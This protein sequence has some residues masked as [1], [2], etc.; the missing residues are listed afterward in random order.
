MPQYLA[1]L[2]DH[3]FLLNDVFQV[4]AL[5]QTERFQDATLDIYD[6][7]LEEAAKYAE[8]VLAPINRSGDEEGCHLENGAVKTPSGFP[9]A[10]G[11]FREGGWAGISAEIEHG[12][13]GLPHSL[14]ILVDEI[15]TAANP[16]FG[17]YRGLIDGAYRTILKYGSD[18]LKESYLHRLAT[19][20]LLPTM[21]L[22]EPHC[23]SDL[24]LLRTRAE[25]ENDG[26]Y[27]ITGTKIFIT[28]GEHDLTPNILHLVLARL[29]DAPAGSR[30]ISLFLVPKLYTGSDGAEIR[31]SLA[32]GGIEHKMGLKASATCV[33]N[34]DGAKGWLLGPPHGGLA[35]MF[36]MMNSARLGV[37]MQGIAAIEAVLQISSTYAAERKQGKAPGVPGFGPDAITH[38]PDVRRMIQTQKAFAEGGR[39]LAL[40]MALAIDHSHCA[41]DP[42]E[43]ERHDELAQLLTPIVK[44][45]LTDAGNEATNIGLQILGG[46]GY[47]REW[48]VEQWVRDIRIAAIY[49]GTNGIQG[50]D[51]V[52]RKLT[53]K[54]GRLPK[55][56]FESLRR[57]FDGVSVLMPVF[58]VARDA[59]TSLELITAR[60]QAADDAIRA[61]VA[62]EFLS[63]FGLVALSG[64]WAGIAQAAMAKRDD[65]PVFCQE[66]LETAEFYVQRILPRHLALVAAIYTV[67]EDTSSR[68]EQVHMHARSN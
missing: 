37:G 43:R 46:H 63:L 6:A 20:E 58:G 65:D 16:G 59:L 50:L 22:T 34:Y 40:R 28:G 35:A 19:G 2:K 25:P 7:V 27:R 31:N 49:E 29:P 48:G 13:Q 57:A 67:L 60:I 45:F 18:L 21:N 52:G 11:L 55:V 66:K 62:S 32:C 26:T 12:G 14:Y 17:M 64:E 15:I 39:A 3:R 24:G 36:T 53:M 1:P 9:E 10:Y 33:M 56:Y 61:D 23:G 30:G 42:A 68:S 44:A 47:I 5:S 8:G 54:G 4:S 51:L 38:H 41:S